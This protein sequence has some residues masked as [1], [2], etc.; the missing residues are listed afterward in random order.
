MLSDL[1]VAANTDP[2]APSLDDTMETESEVDG[3]D[4]DIPDSASQGSNDP[5]HQDA[6]QESALKLSAVK[7]LPLRSLQAK[8]NGKP[9]EL[10]IVN[11]KLLFPR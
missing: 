10:A 11:I 6:D 3:D 8:A 7:S 4:A 2:A 5:A 1:Y 9:C